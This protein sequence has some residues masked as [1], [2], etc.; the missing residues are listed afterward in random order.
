MFVIDLLLVVRVRKTYN[1]TVC[2]KKFKT[3]AALSE[4][5]RLHGIYMNKVRFIVLYNGPYAK[6]DMAASV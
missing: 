1:C 2:D 3:T 6:A 5:M 4:H